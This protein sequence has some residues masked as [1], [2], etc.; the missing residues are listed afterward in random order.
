MK[1]VICE[2]GRGAPMAE[3]EKLVRAALSDP[4]VAI[5]DA[6]RLREDLWLDDLAL[7]ELRDAIE[8]TTGIKVVVSKMHTVGDLKRAASSAGKKSAAAAAPA[9]AAVAAK[10]A[11]DSASSSGKTNA[12]T[13]KKVRIEHGFCS[14]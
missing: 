2:C 12:D 14:S 13:F 7:L 6:S 3:V 10:P 1:V 9:P 4:D 11:V 5:T 8:A